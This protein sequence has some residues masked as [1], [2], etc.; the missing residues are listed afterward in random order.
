MENEDSQPGGKAPRRG[1]M[2][3][4]L[5][6]G[7]V[8]IGLGGAGFQVAHMG[9][10]DGLMKGGG[11]ADSTESHPETL[12]VPL[13]TIMVSLSGNAAH[14]QLRLTAQL[15]VPA[16]SAAEATRLV[17]RILDV[18]NTYL[19]SVDP[20]VFDE[21]MALVR[22]RDHLLYRSRLVAGEE[23]VLDFLITEF[24]VS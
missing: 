14:R 8:A 9:Y 20:A 22:L 4:L 23:S 24:L 7:L 21:P 6:V 15:E 11:H 5:L 16:E 3:P 2:V 17:P 18:T 13:G 19:H 1:R 10:L 12:F